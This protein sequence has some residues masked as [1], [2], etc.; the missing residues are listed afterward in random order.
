MGTN[1]LFIDASGKILTVAGINTKNEVI[2]EESNKSK[3]TLER[4]F[5]VI[6]DI[7]SKLG[8]KYKDI[9]EMYVTLGPGSNT[10]LRIAITQARVFFAFKPNSNVFGASSFNVLFN[11]SKQ[12]NGIVLLSD[13]HD[14][15]FYGIYENNLLID[16]GHSDSYEGIP[17]DKN[18]PFIVS[19]KDEAALAINAPNKIIVDFNS[20]LIIKEAYKK[21]TPDDIQDLIP[22]YN[23][24]I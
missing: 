18:L 21:Y 11:G 7:A 1:S 15:F 4:L 10:G 5:P 14:S 2:V 24:K 8:I 19:N 9:D 20:A 12:K 22:I 17:N 16:K 13:R 6:I 3:E 23:N